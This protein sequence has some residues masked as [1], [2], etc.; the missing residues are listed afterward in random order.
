MPQWIAREYFARRGIAKFTKEQLAQARCSLLGY[1][2]LRV[3]V[4]GV[5]IPDYF[6]H[7]ERQCEVGVE[8]YDQGSDLLYQ[9]FRKNLNDYLIPDLDPLGKKIINC[10]LDKGTVDDF[11]SLISMEM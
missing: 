8:A 4:E 9:F 3:V 11:N 7:V 5:Q 6:F 10:C 1:T 2:P